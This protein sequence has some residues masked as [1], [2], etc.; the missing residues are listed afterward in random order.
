MRY[1]APAATS[2]SA[3]VDDSGLR[4]HMGMIVTG[5]SGMGV[6]WGVRCGAHVPCGIFCGAGI[7]G[8]IPHMKVLKKH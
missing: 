7:L 3:W 6:Q 1:C 8:E 2:T 5:L 4:P